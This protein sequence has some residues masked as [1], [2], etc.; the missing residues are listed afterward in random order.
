MSVRVM[1]A[2][3]E[4]PLPP[5]EKLVLLVIADH[6]DDNGENAYPGVA[7]IAKRA[8]ITERHTRRILQELVREGWLSIDRQ[9]GG[10]VDL[11]SDR[12]PNRYRLN[13]VTSVSGRIADGVTPVSERGDMGVRNGVTPMSADTSLEPS[14][15]SLPSEELLS[16]FNEFWV[17]YPRKVGKRD[18]QTTFVRLMR[19]QEA[20]TQDQ[21][22]RAVAGL[23]AEGREMRFIPHPA[24]WLRQGRWDDEMPTQE[25]EP[26][27]VEKPFCGQCQRGWVSVIED[28]GERLAR[29]D[30][31][32]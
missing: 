30:C 29:C 11:R 7:R 28:G 5:T 6:A 13:G 2:I 9:M 14:T 3:W 18:A 4:L 25:A 26:V 8:S 31:Q 1:A 22:L 10:G 21:V 15:N 27:F 16:R 12:R 17:A 24:T 20:P 23:I 19:R 32:S